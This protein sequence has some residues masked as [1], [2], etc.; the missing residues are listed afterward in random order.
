MTEG[1]AKD[2]TLGFPAMSRGLGLAVLLSGSLFSGHVAAF[3]RTTNCDPTLEPS[4]VCARDQ[5]ECLATGIPLFWPDTCV[6]FGT[7][8]DGSPL[9]KI[10]YERANEVA[11]RAF[12]EWISADCGQG[13][14]PSIGVVPRGEI[15]CD[16]IEFNY[17]PNRKLSAPNANLIVFRDA[18]WPYDDVQRT[19]ALTTITF[20]RKTGQILDADIEVNSATIPLSTGDTGV[21]SDLQS[22]L[23]HEIGHLFGLAHSIE[24]TSSMNANYDRGDLSFRSLSR[25]DVAGICAAYPPGETE[26]GSCQGE[27]PRFGFSRYCG[28]PS[29]EEQADA[30]CVARVVGTPAGRD[31]GSGWVL[32]LAFAMCGLAR[33]RRRCTTR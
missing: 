28:G 32:G 6:T 31:V 8:V 18:A 2:W 24:P 23:T 14:R 16:Q 3:C 1:R 33:A 22:V 26:I 29:L 12:Q 25:D 15:Y 21:T 7:H 27:Q 4:G 30:G 9:R 5:D 20:E 17:D 10:S 13:R 11:E 19:I